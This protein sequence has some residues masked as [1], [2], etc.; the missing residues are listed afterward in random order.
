MFGGGERGLGLV[1]GGEG[2]G[3]VV[4][5][6]GAVGELD[7]GELQVVA[8]LGEVVQGEMGTAAL[9]TGL[10]VVGVLLDQRV[11]PGKRLVGLAARELQGRGPELGL[12]RVRREFQGAEVSRERLVRPPQILQRPA[13]LKVGLGLVGVDLDGLV[14]L[15]KPVRRAAERSSIEP[16]PIIAPTYSLS[17][18]SAR[19]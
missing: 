5:D 6:L 16:R 14:E 4:V 9:M 12:E 2:E 1:V 17:S 11:E 19:R 18:A 13:S 10:G 8:G 3:Q 7:R 15:R